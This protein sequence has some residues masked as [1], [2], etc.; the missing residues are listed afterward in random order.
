M[1][2]ESS[3]FGG[4]PVIMAPTTTY[5]PQVVRQPVRRQQLPPTWQ[6]VDKSERQ[7]IRRR[8]P[9]V[10]MQGNRPLT[11]QPKIEED[12]GPRPRIDPQLISS[13][14]KILIPY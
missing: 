13:K 11:S 9:E 7:S 2:C 10:I 3:S 5:R 14:P 4:A 12:I 1:A 6:Q 8:R